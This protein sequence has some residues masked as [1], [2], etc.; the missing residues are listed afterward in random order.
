MTET[1]RNTEA[2]E[3]AAYYREL[4][5]PVY[6]GQRHIVIGGPVAGLVGLAASL[7]KLGAERPFLLGSCVG[8]GALPE[9]EEAEWYSLD[10]RANSVIEEFRQ[11][12]Q[13][14]R[15]LPEAA[16]AALDRFDPERRALVIGAI[17]LSEIPGVGGRACCHGCI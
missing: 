12:E 17:V 8:T 9:P 16:I 13:A 10:Q 2:E 14:L 3:A 5:K 11:Y 4:L 6:R 7:R 1:T 15:D